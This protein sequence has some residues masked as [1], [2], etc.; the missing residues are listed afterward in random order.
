[1]TTDDLGL[2]TIDGMQA[3]GKRITRT[4][5][6]GAQGN[7]GPI[8]ATD[9]EWNCP[10]LQVQCLRIHS[11]PRMGKTVTQFTSLDRSE[12]DASLF[13][14]P[15]ITSWRTTTRPDLS[16]ERLLRARHC[17]QCDCQSCPR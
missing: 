6:A 2:Q 14:V 9:E 1:M 7:D 17:T 3:R 5:P 11:D 13:Q 15:L 10:E 4:I 8:I 16:R 12:P